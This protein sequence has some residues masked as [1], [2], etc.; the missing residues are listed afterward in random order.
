MKNWWLFLL[1]GLILG[2]VLGLFILQLLNLQVTYNQTYGVLEVVYYL[3]T[4]IGVLA[5]ISAVIVALF[6]EEMKRLI[7]REKCSVF[8]EN[9]NF[10]E[11]IY[12][13]DGTTTIESRRYDCSIVIKN[14]G[15][16]EI[17]D[18]SVC[19]ISCKHKEVTS[20]KWKDL[21]IKNRIPLYWAIP[22]RKKETLLVG[23]SKSLLLARINPDGDQSTPDDYSSFPSERRLSIMGFSPDKKYRH[24][25]SWEMI[26][27]INTLHN[28][29]L[30]FKLLVSWTGEWRQREKEMNDETTLKLEI[31]K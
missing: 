21:K 18:C 22:S 23:E 4:P 12:G 1:I 16:K 7:H 2:L 8:L 6:G 29:L 15:G 17:E 28:E 9:D 31:L 11:D 25:G 24:K 30:K 3:V 20:D 5:T 26:Y 19:L 13:Q 27:S 10:V 14:I